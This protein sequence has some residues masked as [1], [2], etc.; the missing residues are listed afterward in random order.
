MYSTFGISGWISYSYLKAE[1][2]LAADD[3]IGYY[4]P[5]NSDQRHTLFLV[6]S[7]DLGKAWSM[8]VRVVYGS[9][10]PHTPFCSSTIFPSGSQA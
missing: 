8:N 1:Q 2:K 6:A 5:R 7:F 9:G 4:F 10:F 3:K